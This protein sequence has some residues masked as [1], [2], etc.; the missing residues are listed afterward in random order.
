[1]L[2]SDTRTKEQEEKNKKRKLKAKARNAEASGILGYC[3]PGYI[4]SQCT[5]HRF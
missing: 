5:A 2:F 4:S 3:A 1:M